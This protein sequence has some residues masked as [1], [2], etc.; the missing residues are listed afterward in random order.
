MEYFTISD[1]SNQGFYPI[2]EKLFNNQHYQK[3]VKKIK[4]IK[5]RE[6]M[7][8]K[9][10]ITT[11]ELISDTSKLMYGIMCRYLNFSLQNG[12]FDEDKRVYIKLSVTTLSKILNKSRDTIVK[13]K[14]QLEDVKLLKIIKTKY[15]SDIFYLGKVKD[16][17]KD[18]IFMEIEDQIKAAKILEVEDVDQSK[19]SDELVEDVDSN[20]VE[21]VDSNKDMLI[22]DHKRVVAEKK[23]PAAASDEIILKNIKELIVKNGFKNYNSQT[24]KNIKNYSKGS[25]EE[26]KKVIKFMKLKNKSLNSKILVAILKDKDHLVVDPIDIKKVPRKEKIKFMVEKL[27]EYQIRSMRNKILKDIGYEC[28]GVDDDLGNQLCKKYN[29]LK[30]QEGSI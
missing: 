17:P 5:E 27:G 19:L 22:R 20:L 11:E 14:K 9:E 30:T 24:L 4:K 21:D 26:V 16:K 12:W 23:D 6:V 8:P 7:V 3:K 28:Q 2:P 10:V 1:I 13:S 29:K 25:T 15:E 18:D